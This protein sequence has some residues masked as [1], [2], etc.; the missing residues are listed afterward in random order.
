MSQ[1]SNESGFKDEV[2][3]SVDIEASGPIPSKFSML[4]I[5]ACVVGDVEKNFYAEM[6]PINDSFIP[7]AMKVS[8]LTLES[9]RTNGIDPTDVMNK[10]S[11]WVKKVSNHKRAVLVGFNAPFDWQFVNW[12]FH[13]YTGDNP[14]GISAIDIKAYI[15][16]ATHS[17]WWQT[18][19]SQ[20]PEW[21]QVENKKKHNA[22]SDATAQ[23]IIFERLLRGKKY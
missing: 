21:L 3:I 16:G 2:Y 6:K 1:L 9:L 12:Y 11:S 20:L 13:V 15:M 18:S 5:G 14:F 7:E 17:D 10:L 19:S 22:L 8:G 23:A 4:S